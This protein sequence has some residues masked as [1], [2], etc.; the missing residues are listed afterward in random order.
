MKKNL[1][2]LCL[3]VLVSAFTARS[4]NLVVSH[5]LTIPATDVYGMDGADWCSGIATSLS[6]GNVYW[7]YIDNSRNAII[8]KK[9]G[10]TG[11]ITTQ[12]VQADI[13]SDDNHSELSI[14]LDSNGYIHYIGGQHN[15]SP[16][17]YRSTNPEDITSWE[18][19]GNDLA[20]GGIDGFKIT[21]QHFFRSN[22]GTLF[23]AYRSNLVD[24]WV[25]GA[26]SIQMGRYNTTTE[27][28][29]MLGGLNYCIKDDDCI[30]HCGSDL[31]M[32]AIVWDDSGS[33]SGKLDGSCDGC[34]GYN[35]Y[36]GYKFK[37]VFDDNNVLHATWNVA[38][39]MYTSENPAEYHSHVM[40]AYSPDEGNTWYRAGGQQITK[41]P[42]T[43]ETGD[44]D[45]DATIVY[46]RVP[47]GYPND[48]SS[49][50]GLED[51]TM[52]TQ[53]HIVLDNS[54]IPIIKQ[55]V[56]LD[57]ATY[58]FKLDGTSFVDITENFVLDN[59][60]L[61]SNQND[62]MFDV[63]G[64]ELFY[65][66]DNGASALTYNL[67][68]PSDWNVYE[69]QYYL[70]K[71]G[72]L[73]YYAKDA[74]ANV[75]RIVTVTVEPGAAK[76][77]ITPSASLHTS[78]VEVSLST[79][80]E[81]AS[82]RY[83]TDGS[84]PSKTHG[85]LYSGPFNLTSDATVKAMAYT[86]EFERSNVAQKSYYVMD[87]CLSK[88]T[89]SGVEASGYQD[90]N[91]P[92]NSYDNN[93]DTRWSAEGE[94]WIKYDLG[95][96]YYIS[97]IF[98]SFYHGDARI[99]NLTSV[100]TSVDGN[101]W[102][103]VLGSS[104]SS[105]K[106]SDLEKFP[107]QLSQGRYVRVNCN[108]T[109]T[110]GWNSLQEV[111]I[112]GDCENP[113]VY[114][115]DLTTVV[116]GEGSITLNPTGGTY[117]QATSVECEAIPASLDYV[118]DGWSGAIDSK[119]NPVTLTMTSDKSITANFKY[120]P[121][122]SEIII[123]AAGKANTELMELYLNDTL[124]A[125]YFNVGGDYWDD[126][127]VTYSYYPGEFVDAEDIKLKFANNSNERG[128][129]V[130]DIKL[131][132]VV[133]PTEFATN[134]TNLDY[135]GCG[136]H[137]SKFMACGGESH[138][139]QNTLPW[140]TIDLTVI[141]NGTVVDN[142]GND[143]PPVDSLPK[144]K[145]FQYIATPDLGF[146]FDGWT[147]DEVNTNERVTIKADANKSVTATFSPL[148]NGDW[149]EFTENSYA[150]YF[151][152]TTYL[153]GDMVWDFNT[154]GGQE[155]SQ[156]DHLIVNNAGNQ[157]SEFSNH[158]VDKVVDV[159]DNPVLTF[160]LKADETTSTTH[161][162]ANYTVILYASDGSLTYGQYKLAIPIDGQW[163]TY[164]YDIS[165]SWANLDSINQIK[166]DYQDGNNNI[167]HLYMDSL[168]LGTTGG[169]LFTLTTEAM[170]ANTGSVTPSGSGFYKENTNVDVTANDVTGYA[171]D[172]W[173]GDLGGANS[174]D[175][176][177]SIT[178]DADKSLTANFAEV[179]TFTIT[180][181]KSGGDG[182][183]TITFA[184]DA[185]AY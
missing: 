117:D 11:A 14:G 137:Y 130:R 107:L 27:K 131:D 18:F 40:Y 90:P 123:T 7:A 151:D 69:D 76:P 139:N 96:Q 22:N 19:K 150:N 13:P 61:F 113:L 58:Y 12:K 93:F 9:D 48:C 77:E 140:Y 5:E 66:E 99:A 146:Q 98:I 121:P 104:Y 114:Q 84:E 92:A 74:G 170:P 41:L 158:F 183:G 25:R 145:K 56:I 153:A 71:T 166:F 181:N 42:M 162:T 51:Q 50:F 100:E 94:H 111:Q 82:I 112:W 126:E 80:T 46:K 55:Y 176:P 70:A 182:T 95:A 163:H 87:D 148:P 89:I 57:D 67:E 29:E 79:T 21:Y 30:D 36:Q 108:G 125:S 32:N 144:D 38:K 174:A 72:K 6:T 141:G 47:D 1:F 106:T 10:S 172:H 45:Q 103:E 173:T 28:W 128:I 142:L 109:N 43:C 8:A 26:R 171:F 17:Y 161:D 136:N 62:V 63:K 116:E 88:L 24:E 44:T 152:G 64:T 115:Y 164:A 68:Y 180:T 49:P 156:N 149:Y 157:W 37:A 20:N 33:G 129:W 65:S 97:N 165:N 75:A 119:E 2:F 138:Y 78:S 147:G 16:N 134:L 31:N 177:V 15:N 91:V 135:V 168:M 105:G 120:R 175:N 60:H 39:N 154:Y 4:Q 160:Q 73:R 132:N 102:T 85:T 167:F 83:T 81:G 169:N 178:M 53:G 35:H 34:T 133:Y 52:G 110:S 23:C 101:S 124:K 86:S 127:W 184:P 185:T 54:G 179:D 155:I 59:K 159:S 143:D 118:F 122:G 3:I